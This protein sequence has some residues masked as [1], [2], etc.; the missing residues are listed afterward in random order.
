MFC[1]NCVMVFWWRPSWSPAATADFDDG[2]L[3]YL[4]AN[5]RSADGR[6]FAA[7]HNVGHVTLLI[8]DADGQ[9][10]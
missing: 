5:I 3:Q 2:Q 7:A 1:E 10:K 4:V 9:H 6:Q 8:F